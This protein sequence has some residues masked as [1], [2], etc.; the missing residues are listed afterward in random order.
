LEHNVTGIQDE[1]LTIKD[2]IPDEESEDPEE[3]AI[4]MNIKNSMQEFISQRIATKKMNDRDAYILRLRYGL[5]D[6]TAYSLDA[7]GTKVGLTRERVRQLQAEGLR[8]L[9]E[10]MD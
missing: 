6:N 10:L 3:T 1:N 9:H 2:C 4:S 5:H 8:S 7:I